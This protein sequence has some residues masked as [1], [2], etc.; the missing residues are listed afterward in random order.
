M[1]IIEYDNDQYRGCARPVAMPVYSKK[2]ET[3]VN[4]SRADIPD[5][6]VVGIS[7]RL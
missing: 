4:L 7:T 3:V 2:K 6:V 5:L 1:I